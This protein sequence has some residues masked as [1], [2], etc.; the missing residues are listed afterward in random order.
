MKE[1]EVIVASVPDRDQ[2]V[3]EIWLEGKQLAEVRRA[4]DGFLAEIYPQQ[5]AAL[6]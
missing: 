1:L 5:P 3:A 4:N 2:V 6:P